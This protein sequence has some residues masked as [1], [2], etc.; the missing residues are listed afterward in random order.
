MKINLL[1]SVLVSLLVTG[2]GESNSASQPGLSKLYQEH[3]K[4]AW[5]VSNQGKLPLNECARV[6]GTAVG[7][8]MANRDE[9]NQ[10]QQAYEACY[11]DAFVNYANV[12][13]TLDDNAKIERDNTPQ[14]C[15]KF[16]QSLRMHKSIVGGFADKFAVDTNALDQRIR[17]GLSETAALCL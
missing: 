1:L 5:V 14:G 2:C 13:F 4:E 15:L 11:V 3:F 9:N 16:A 6:V 17:S 7:M 8:V 10:A 12:Y